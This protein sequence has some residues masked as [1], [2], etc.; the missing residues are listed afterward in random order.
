MTV[1][2]LFCFGS[3]VFLVS[4]DLFVPRVQDVE[5]WFGFELRGVAARVTAPLHWA[6]FLIGGWGF[7]R[8]RAWVRPAAAGYC[9]YIGGCHL[10]WNLV[11]S[12]GWGWIAGVAEALVFSLPGI[13]LLRARD[14]AAVPR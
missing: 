14:A 5:V 2:A 8:Q 13:L 9:F 3:T 12:N 6:I 10:I 4:R 7:W 1:L 11:S